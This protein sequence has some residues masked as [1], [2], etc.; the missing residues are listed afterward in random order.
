VAFAGRPVESDL[1]AA[2]WLAAALAPVPASGAVVASLVPPV[3]A[4][5]ARVF[6]P[7]VRYAGNDDVEVGWAVVAAANGTRAH[8]LMQWGSVTGSLEYFDNED[9]APLWH[10]APAR[11]HLPVPVA[12]R[13]VAVLRR[14]TGT[15]GDCW[16]GVAESLGNP[17]ATAPALHLPRGAA[18]LVRGP[19]ELAAANFADEPSDQ[20]P[21]LWWPRD[22]AWCVATDPDLVSTYVAGSAACIADLLAAPRLEAAPAEPWQSVTGGADRINPPPVETVDEP[23]GG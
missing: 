7:A 19:L 1:S 17:T 14:H 16:F 3:F 15:P 11:G 5:Y 9:Q 18:W 2:A 22:R 23:G 4:A 10:G 21:S 20:S 6:H 8:P 13:L 12:E